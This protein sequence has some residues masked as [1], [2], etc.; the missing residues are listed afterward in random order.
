L[1]ALCACLAVAAAPALTAP[2]AAGAADAPAVEQY[3]NTL[4]GVPGVD[5]NE[6]DPIVERSHRVGPVGVVGEQD[7]AVPLSSAVGSAVATPGGLA[8]VV[9]FAGGAALAL[10]RRP[11]RR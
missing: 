5:I 9:V 1:V 7:G 11:S 8:L 6:T 4:P 2:T 10:A 3:V